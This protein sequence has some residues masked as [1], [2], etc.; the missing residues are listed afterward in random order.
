VVSSALERIEDEATAEADL[1]VTA[2]ALTASARPSGGLWAALGHWLCRA[3][4]AVLP[5]KRV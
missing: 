1:K 2:E 5:L 3:S 4:A